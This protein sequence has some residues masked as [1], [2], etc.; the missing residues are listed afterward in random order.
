MDDI[1]KKQTSNFRT[2][3]Q[4]GHFMRV[5]SGVDLAIAKKERLDFLTLT[6]QYD[7]ERP[8]QRLKRSKDLNYA[9]TKLK[10]KIEYY[11]QKTLYNRFCRKNLLKPYEIHGRKKSIKYPEYWAMY[12]CKLRYIKVKTSEGGGVLHVIFRKPSSYPPIPK[13]W[14][15]SEW[16]KI[17]GSWNTSIDEVPIDDAYRMSSYVVGKYFI[18]QPVIRMSYGQ[19][20]V[21]SGFVKGFRKVVEIYANMRQS[22][23]NDRE[24]HT[25]FKRAI[26]VWNKNIDNGC[27]PKS[28]YQKRLRWRRLPEKTHGVIGNLETKTLQC[29]IDSPKYAWEYGSTIWTIFTRLPKKRFGHSKITAFKSFSCMPIIIIRFNNRS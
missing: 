25:P 4:K 9:F 16:L 18:D 29:C 17:W 2:K 22:P 14:L 11:W 12:R 13:S 23:K 15:H 3:K 8:E 28:S 1:T 21:Y 27:L 7:K 6:T 26:E 5:R 10:Q 20:W 24:K 19:Q